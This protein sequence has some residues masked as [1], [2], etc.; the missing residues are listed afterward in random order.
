MTT[1][2][3]IRITVPDG[4]SALVASAIAAAGLAGVKQAEPMA[5]EQQEHRLPDGSMNGHGA[6]R[7]L[8]DSDC[9]PPIRHA[10]HHAIV[11]GLPFLDG[12]RAD[13]DSRYLASN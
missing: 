1:N 11:H 5:V 4:S 13:Y 2:E 12:I 8:L 7:G 9:E 10:T 6:D 3:S